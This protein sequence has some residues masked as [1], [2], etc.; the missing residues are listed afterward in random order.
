MSISSKK[1]FTLIE[2]LVVIAIIGILAAVILISLTTARGKAN[3]VRVMSAAK[4]IRTQ[5]ESDYGGASYPDLTNVSPLFG[6]FVAN[7]N[8]GSSTINTLLGDAFAQ[9]GGINIVVNPNTDPVTGYAIYGQLVSSS[10][11]FFC[12]DS[13]G[14]TNQ[15]A[16]TNNTTSCP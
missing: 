15:L 16:S 3:D 4:Q 10:T 14:H 7:G 13:T 8:P 11:Q 6:G 5:L 1:G 9:G 2:L 12:I